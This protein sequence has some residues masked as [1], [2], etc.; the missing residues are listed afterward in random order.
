MAGPKTQEWG[1]TS[2]WRNLGLQD[3]WVL[4]P[5][6]DANWAFR[7]VAAKESSEGLKANDNKGSL[8]VAN[9]KRIQSN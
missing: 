8:L 9:I 4:G 2:L 1:D 5:S 6:G 7:H 3:A